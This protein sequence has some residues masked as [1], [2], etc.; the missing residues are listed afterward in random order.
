MEIKK[1]VY[2]IGHKNP[3]V[4]SIAAAISYAHFKNYQAGQEYIPAA[5]GA[6]NSE[7]QFVLQQLGIEPPLVLSSVATTA[8]DLLDGQ[9]ITTRADVDLKTLGGLMREQAV[10][11]V[12]VV[13]EGGG[14]WA[15]SLSAIWPCCSWNSWVRKQTLPKTLGY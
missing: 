7:S 8:E 14:S 6:I 4:D 5:A 1:P 11:T 15:W 2:V 13:D 9:S 10:K 12:P 3:D